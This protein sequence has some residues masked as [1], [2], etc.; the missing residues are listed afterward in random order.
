[1]LTRFVAEPI[2]T[3]SNLSFIVFG[4]LGATHEL[5]QRSK[6]SYVMLHSTVVMVG[7]GSM[8]FHGTLTTWGQQLDELPMV[9]HLLTALD[10][11]NREATT[12]IGTNKDMYSGLLITYALIFSIGHMILQTTTAFQ[13]HFG[14]LLGLALIRMY[15]RF[16]N[17]DAGPNGPLLIVLFA[18]SGILAF[19]CWLLDYHGCAYVSQLPINPHGHMWWHIG[20]GYSAYCSVVMLKVFE[21]AEAG[22]LLDIKFWCGLPFAYR[23]P[24]VVDMEYGSENCQIF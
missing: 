18:I 11:L 22:K 3:L 5:R 13:V 23:T 17:V 6:R 15:K 24:G 19:S 4:I 8:L 21:S 16:H 10:C 20:M 1:M 2:N 9:W 7:I 12:S 14:V